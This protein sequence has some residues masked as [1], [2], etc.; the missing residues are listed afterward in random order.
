M[1]ALLVM[2]CIFMW[3]R[4]QKS[5]CENKRKCW[6]ELSRWIQAAGHRC[7]IYLDFPSGSNMIH[8]VIN[9]Y[10]WFERSGSELVFTHAFTTFA[11]LLLH[12]KDNKCHV[13]C[14]D[15]FLYSFSSL[16][17]RINAL[18]N[19]IMNIWLLDLFTGISK[20]FII[21]QCMLPLLFL[22]IGV[23]K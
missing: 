14:T 20:V 8:G 22:G 11:L 19:I 4:W 5:G 13:V 12:G 18:P 16:L 10:V 2:E 9:F 17:F 6:L 21:F 23:Y 3:K 1:D 7:L 15:A